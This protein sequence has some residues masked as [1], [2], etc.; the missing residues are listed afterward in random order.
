MACMPP[1]VVVVQN[2]FMLLPLAAFFEGAGVVSWL[3]D[4]PLPN[5]GQNTALALVVFSGVLAF[6]LNFSLFFAI[7]A[8]SAMTFNVAGNL[9]VALAILLGWL[10]FRNPVSYLNAL[11]CTITVV[12]CTWYGYVM[13]TA[14]AP[15]APQT[16]G[17]SSPTADR[18]NDAEYIGERPTPEKRKSYLVDTA[19]DDDYAEELKPMLNGSQALATD[20]E[21]DEAAGNH[22]SR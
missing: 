4:D 19:R 13:S 11:G 7:Q 3:M 2:M 14:N 15:P 20:M 9:K 16:S 21:D 8:T 6:G 12:G 18:D 22:R 10:I 1:R 17:L 5:G